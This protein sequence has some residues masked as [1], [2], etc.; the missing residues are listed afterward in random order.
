MIETLS[1]ANCVGFLLAYIIGSFNYFAMA[2]V[3]IALIAVSAG[4]L[5]ILPETPLYLVKAEKIS[6]NEMEPIIASN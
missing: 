3:S 6:V 4:L 2:E 5:F 1:I